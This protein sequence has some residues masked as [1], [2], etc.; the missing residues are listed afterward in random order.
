MRGL[1][2]E[3]KKTFGF[4][5]VKLPLDGGFSCPHLASGA[6]L[7]CSE[8][9][10]GDFTRPGSIKD[11]L[12]Y[13]KKRLGPAQGYIGYF[14]NFTGTFASRDYLERVYY[15]ALEDPQVL[16]LAIATRVDCLEEEVLE[17]LEELNK[18]TYLWLELGLQSANEEVM[19]L[20]NLGYKTSDYIEAM[21]RLRE[22][23]IRVV[24]H[25]I[26]GLPGATQEDELETAG[27]ILDEGS[28][29]IK[30]HSLYVQRG[31]G[32]AR[33]YEEGLYEPLGFDDYVKRAVAVLDL[34]GDRLVVHRLTGDS[35]REEL[36]APL[37]TLDKRRVLGTIQKELA[38]LRKKKR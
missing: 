38:S 36:L 10:S 22:R 27:L 3:L 31:T 12:A 6:C 35:P 13:Q 25:M 24:T 15:E 5:L 30:I 32:L 1:A 28:W 37:W 8:R 16:A 9:G 14:Q 17:L 18:R 2:G 19:E 26:L 23:K 4:R 21:K 7:F 29:G 34:L 11:Q 33:L 20:V